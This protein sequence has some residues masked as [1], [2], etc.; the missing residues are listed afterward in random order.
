MGERIIRR[1]ASELI[2]VVEPYA[3]GLL[4]L[5]PEELWHYT[6]AEVTAMLKSKNKP[7]ELLTQRRETENED[8]MTPEEIGKRLQM[9]TAVY[10]RDR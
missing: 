2:E 5:K 8:K 10:Q 6:P 9:I 4:N 1:F 7:A 3:Y